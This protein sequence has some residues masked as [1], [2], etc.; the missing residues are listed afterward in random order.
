MEYFPER[1]LL[2]W[3]QVYGEFM[4]LSSKLM[5]LLFVCYGLYF[6]H[7][8]NIVHRDLKT[9]N[10]LI[11]SKMVTKIIDFGESYHLSL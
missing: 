11:E 3:F 8:N 2:H 5:I 10:I 9:S 6:L 7:E 4:S 1:S